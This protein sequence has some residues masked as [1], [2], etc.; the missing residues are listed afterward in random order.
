VVIFDDVRQGGLRPLDRRL[1]TFD[2]PP[3]SLS[4]LQM[5]KIIDL[6]LLETP[7][8]SYESFL[9]SVCA[10]TAPNSSLLFVIHFV[11]VFFT[12]I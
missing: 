1:M 4:P 10:A 9:A 6:S 12:G 8:N 2:L 7:N 11:T 3:S 5:P